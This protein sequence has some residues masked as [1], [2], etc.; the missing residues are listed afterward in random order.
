MSTFFSGKLTALCEE[1]D[2]L[3]FEHGDTCKVITAIA[4]KNAP[5]KE[6]TESNVHPTM[7]QALAP[8]L[9]GIL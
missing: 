1:V 4:E 2:S 8:F 7:M 9:R 3:I 5:K 6:Q